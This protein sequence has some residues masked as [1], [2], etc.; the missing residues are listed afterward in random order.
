MKHILIFGGAGFI[1]TNL[2]TKLKDQNNIILCVD[3]FQTGRTE[4]LRQFVN[5][6]NVH[7]F[8]GDITVNIFKSLENL[9]Y[10]KFNNHIDEIYNLA[11]PASPPKYL[12]N[13]IHTINTSL[14][15]QTICKLAM[16]YDA[17]LL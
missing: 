2:V 1:G 4:N 7:W 9:I 5:N 6:D 8:K 13:P 14:S 11:C 3:N 17:N 16:K 12:K 10:N 15:I